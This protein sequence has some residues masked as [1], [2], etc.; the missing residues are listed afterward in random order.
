MDELERARE[1]RRKLYQRLKQARAALLDTPSPNQRRALTEQVRL[2]GEMYREACQEVRRLD[3]AQT[4]TPA[5]RGKKGKK[6]P[7]S[8]LDSALACGA[9]WTDLEGMRWSSLEG[10][11]WD[12]LPRAQTG[13]QA[14]LAQDLVRRAASACSPVQIQYLHAYYVQELT[15]EEI[16]QRFG[17]HSSTVSRTLARARDR[18]GRFIRARLL[19]GRCVDGQGRFDY[20]L[21]LHSAQLLT[22]R[23]K[24]LV[25]LLLARDTSCRDIARFIGRTPSTVQRTA[26]RVEEKLDGLALGLLNGPPPIRADRRDWEKRSE[27]ELAQDLGLSPAFYYRIVRRGERLDGLPLLACAIL[28]R[29]AAGEPPDQ[30]AQALGCSQSLVRR[31]ARAWAGRPLP[32]H[33]E[34]YTPKVTRKVRLPSNPFAAL[35]GGGDTLLDRIDAH[36]YRTLQ[37]R[38]GEPDHADP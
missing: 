17:V 1:Q 12:C 21:F 25:F 32:P 34:P 9:V 35:P 10:K 11:G 16:G 8:R 2:L 6:V 3:P 27:K 31:T 36:T 30:T 22:E 5:P 24:E 14:R 23:Q 29:L 15:L 28:N 4:L 7:A 18:M 38:F 20:M 37:T 33:P 26:G 19:L 13:R